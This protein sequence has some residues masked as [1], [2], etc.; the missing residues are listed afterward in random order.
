[1][2]QPATFFLPDVIKQILGKLHLE[3][4]WFESTHILTQVFPGFPQ[5]LQSNT[6]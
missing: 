2:S 1:L 5:F 3:G 6:E 4:T